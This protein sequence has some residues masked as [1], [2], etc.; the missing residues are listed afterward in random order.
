[1]QRYGVI[2]SRYV[3]HG[4]A[5]PWHNGLV[6]VPVEW[7]VVQALRFQK[8][9]RVIAFNGSDEQTLGIVGVG[10]YDGAQAGNVSEERLRALAMGLAPIDAPAGGHADGEGRGEVAGTAIPQPRRF[11]DDLVGGRVEV[12]C[13]LDFHDWAKAVCPHANC[14]TNNAALGYG[15]VEHAVLSVRCLKAFRAANHA[16]EVA[17]VLHEHHYVLV[18]FKHD[19]HGRAQCLNHGHGLG[20]LT[21]FMY[22]RHIYTPRI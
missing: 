10:R 20:A 22:I 5:R 16:T 1:T 14:R 13:K 12:V 8:D 18:A 21:D 19:V 6:V 3:A 17:D 2:T 7:P 15:G 4:V 11:R 9:D